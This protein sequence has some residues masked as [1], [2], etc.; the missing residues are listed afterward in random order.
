LERFYQ[1]KE[2]LNAAQNERKIY[3]KGKYFWR[4]RGALRKETIFSYFLRFFF[5][6]VRLGKKVVPL[7]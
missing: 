4:F 6:V 3:E 1:R 7:K 2:L 5:P